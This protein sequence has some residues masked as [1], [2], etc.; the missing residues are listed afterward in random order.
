[1]RDRPWESG[2]VQDVAHP[3]AQVAITGRN[4]VG[5]ELTKPVGKDD[6]AWVP[7]RKHKGVAVFPLLHGLGSAGQPLLEPLG[8]VVDPIRGEG[9]APSDPDAAALEVYIGPHEQPRLTDPAP[10]ASHE[11]QQVELRDRYRGLPEAKL[12]TT[13]HDSR[14]DQLHNSDDADTMHALRTL[15]RR[16]R[17]LADEISQLDERILRRAR[18]ANPALMA[19]KGVGPA[20]GAQLSRSPRQPNT[21]AYG[22][23]ESENSNSAD[24]PTP[25]SQCA[26]ENGST[27]LD[28]E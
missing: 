5:R 9:L 10:R 22:P 11:G 18:R 7:Q 19:I 6:L 13:L 21:S 23:H 1:M 25:N 4:V 8:E 3:L 14:P 2:A 12:L 28:T 15:A 27:P 26:T 24:A 17:A 20:I 16:H